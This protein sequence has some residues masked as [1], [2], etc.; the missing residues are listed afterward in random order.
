MKLIAPLSSDFVA[1]HPRVATQNAF[2]YILNDARSEHAPRRLEGNWE[3]GTPET[4]AIAVNR[5]S[6]GAHACI[7][8]TIRVFGQKGK[9]SESI[10]RHHK[11]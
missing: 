1:P 3:S 2:N 9:A 4:S 6:S 7:V 5:L 8:G 11:N 10:Y